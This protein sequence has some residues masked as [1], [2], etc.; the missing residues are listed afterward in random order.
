MKPTLEQSKAL[1]TAFDHFN[2]FLFQSQLPPCMV[3]FSRNAN[4]IGG[5]Y[6]ADMWE[7][8]T[9]S[10]E[11]VKIPEIAINAN[12][13]KSSGLVNLYCHLAH[14]MVHHWQSSFGSPGS[15]GYH[16][17][18]WAMKS[19]LIGLEPKSEHGNRTGKR[20]VTTLIEGSPLEVAIRTMPVEGVVMWETPE[21]NLPSGHP[22]AVPVPVPVPTAPEPFEPSAES[23]RGV[24]SKY[25]CPVCGLNAW[26]KP[27]AQ[28]QCFKDTKLMVEAKGV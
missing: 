11:S 28:L 20:I 6:A 1:Q 21:L 12:I 26:A 18:E 9:D 16:N 24:R 13:M 19:V 14:E 10:G 15:E 7:Q 2:E 4:I 17:E 23:K 22:D 27:G 5:Y 3:T 25:T 8:H